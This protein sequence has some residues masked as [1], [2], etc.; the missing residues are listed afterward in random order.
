MKWKSMFWSGISDVWRKYLDHFGHLSSR[1]RN[2]STLWKVPLDAWTLDCLMNSWPL[3]RLNTWWTHDEDLMKTW[4]TPKHFPPLHGRSIASWSP[5]L[6]S[7]R[8]MIYPTPERLVTFPTLERLMTGWMFVTWL[9]LRYWLYLNVSSLNALN[10]VCWKL[11][12]KNN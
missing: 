11:K 10:D 1:Q 7:Q 3:E 8:L 5:Q 9:F 6:R 2:A 12:K 4:W